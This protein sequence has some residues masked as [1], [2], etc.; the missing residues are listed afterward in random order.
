M[1]RVIRNISKPKPLVTEPHRKE[2][3]T[4]EHWFG[5]ERGKPRVST[6]CMNQSVPYYTEMTEET[7]CCAGWK[8]HGRFSLARSKAMVNKIV[9][10]AE[11][12]LANVRKEKA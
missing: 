9:K 1:K 10:E 3:G 11:A 6:L 12:K 7:F 5:T 2:C 4:C 8:E